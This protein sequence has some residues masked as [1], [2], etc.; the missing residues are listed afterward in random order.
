MPGD[1]KGNNDLLVTDAAGRRPRASTGRTS[2]AG[3]DILETNTFNAT[4]HRAWRTTAMDPTWSA[5]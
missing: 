3:A 1:L 5:S 2:T 4:S